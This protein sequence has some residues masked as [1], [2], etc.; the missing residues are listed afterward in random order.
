MKKQGPSGSGSV[1]S[2]SKPPK[3]VGGG[4]LPARGVMKRNA[5]RSL[6]EVDELDEI[7]DDEIAKAKEEKV[8]GKPAKQRVRS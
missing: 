6:E 4:D 1:L 5:K 3:Q 2:L 8:E 7:E